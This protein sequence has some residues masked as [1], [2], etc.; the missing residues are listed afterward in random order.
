MSDMIVRNIY[1]YLDSYLF[2]YIE[3]DLFLLSKILLVF[4]NKGYA[5]IFYCRK[6]FVIERAK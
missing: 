3:V 4:K 2:E 5:I 1:R 6:N